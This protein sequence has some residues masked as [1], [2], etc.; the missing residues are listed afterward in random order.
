MPKPS[1]TH[2]TNHKEHHLQENTGFFEL[3]DIMSVDNISRIEND[4]NAK[5]SS[6][7][8]SLSIFQDHSIL[9]S[10]VVHTCEDCGMSPIV[11]PKYVCTE[12]D[13][14]YLCQSCKEF[15][16]KDMDHC[17]KHRVVESTLSYNF[18]LQ[19][20]ISTAMKRDSFHSR[21]TRST[22]KKGFREDMSA[23]FIFSPIKIAV[24]DD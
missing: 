12:C 14:F 1:P 22:T 23:V 10:D 7:N 11:G 13:D 16:N 24:I 19:S 3:A 15:P 21:I 18:M 5:T 8:N 2:Q 9:R 4:P 20:Q 17:R 6:L